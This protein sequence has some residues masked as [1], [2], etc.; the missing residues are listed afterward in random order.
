[1]NDQT[2]QELNEAIRLNPEDPKSYYR[3]GN[4]RYAKGDYD[5]AIADY[6]KALQLDPAYAKAYIYRIERAIDHLRIRGYQYA[7]KGEYELAIKDFNGIIKLDEEK[8]SDGTL[9]YISVDGREY[10][11]AYINRGYAYYKNSDYEKAIADF[12]KALQLAVHVAPAKAAAYRFRGTAY[13]HIGN[14]ERAIADLDET[15]QFNK[16]IQ[17]PVRLG[18]VRLYRSKLRNAEA[19]EP[20]VEREVQVRPRASMLRR[21]DIDTAASASGDYEPV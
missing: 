10:V 14:Y 15:T 6:T 12:D 5:R 1:M 17:L 7:K 13:F 20:Q 9:I 3:R 2:I 16:S 21:N 19:D 8:V 4:A 18:P 11:E